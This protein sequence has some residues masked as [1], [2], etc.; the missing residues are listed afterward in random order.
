MVTAPRVGSGILLMVWLAV[1]GCSDD[2]ADPVGPVGGGATVSFAADVQPIFAANCAGCHGVGGN[3]GLNLAMDVAW[4]NL[5]GIETSGY[6]PRQRVVVANPDQS[7]LYLKLNGAPGVGDR[8]P[9]G[10]MLLDEDIERVRVW[11]VQGAQNN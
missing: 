10:G 5:V 1:G 2:G 4:A 11:I 7:V 8:M 9:Q 6:A 3:G